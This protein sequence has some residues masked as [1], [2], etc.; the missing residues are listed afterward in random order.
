MH[1]VPL[2]VVHVDD[3]RCCRACS[4]RKGDEHRAFR[5]DTSDE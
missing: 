1:V 2:G 3:R 5:S 4:L